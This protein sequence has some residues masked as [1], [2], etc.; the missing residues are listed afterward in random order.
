MDCRSFATELMGLLNDAMLLLEA[1]KFA[2]G[3]GGAEPVGVLTVGT[4]GALT[5]TQRVQT[6]TTAT[7]AYAD[8]WTFKQS[9]PVRFLAD[10][11]IVMNPVTLDTAYQL[12]P[13][14]S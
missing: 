11:V 14:C 13:A 1:S 4:T 5:T 2:T 8:N 12:S 3:A 7:Y 6:A 9:I 10:S